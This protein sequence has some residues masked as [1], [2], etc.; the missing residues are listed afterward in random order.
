MGIIEP[1]LHVAGKFISNVYLRPKLDG[2]VR[3]ILDLTLFNK[4][5][6]YKHFFNVFLG[7]GRGAGYTKLLASQR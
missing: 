1:A 2:M 3:L 4:F 5:V 7:N 6:D